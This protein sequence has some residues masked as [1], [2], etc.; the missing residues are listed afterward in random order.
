M[1][2][3]PR[4]Q[5]YVPEFHLAQFIGL[6]FRRFHVFDKQW[7][8]FGRPP[9]AK[10]A[11]S[12]DYYLLPGETIEERLRL[13]RQ[14]ALLE[15]QVAPLMKWLARQPLGSVHMNDEGR[16]A[17]AGYAAILHIRVPAYREAALAR[18][19]SMAR[20]P[21][22][23]GLADAT[24][25]RD[26]AR[27]MGFPGTDEDLEALRLEWNED[28]RTGRRTI[29]VH[30][31]VSLTALSPAVEK[32][33]P[34]LF[35]R[36]WELLRVDGWQ[37]FV[38]GDQPVTLLSK[39]RLAGQIGFGT[40]D[41]QVMMPIAPNT[42]LLISD[43]PRER[44]LEVKVQPWRLGLREPWWATANRVA[45]LS[46]KRYVFAQ[47][48]WHLQAAEL[49]LHPDDRRRDITGLSAEAEEVM[50]QRSHERRWARR[51]GDAG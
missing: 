44:V 38:I 3:L 34:M 30:K 5:H 16:D 48:P 10:S 47:R 12:R 49:L 11:F 9:V 45:W 7:G 42:M 33:R 21:E 8:K 6:P 19:Q 50:K 39:G 28:V 24:E 15:D 4:S 40:P 26:E 17:L 31:A 23:L 36:A 27:K 32:V 18:A 51:E 29:E 20:D 37:G 2:S 25:F 35:D 1:P 13:E 22:M 46:S 43:R 41:V 14:F